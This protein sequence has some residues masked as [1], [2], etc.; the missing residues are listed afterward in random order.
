[1]ND[2]I[3]HNETF[4]EL[5]HDAVISAAE[6]AQEA[7]GPARV[8]IVAPAGAVRR[9][10]VEAMSR[11]GSAPDEAGSAR[12][13]RRLTARVRFDAVLIDAS[14]PRQ[15]A[16]RL[17][18][19]ITSSASAPAV[20]ML[21]AHPSLDS[22][23]RAIRSGACDLVGPESPEEMS[24]RVLAA[25]GRGRAARAR[26]ERVR[27]LERLCHKLNVARE[28]VVREVGDLCG[29]L[30]GAYQDLTG[31][32]GRI[33]M[34]SEFHGLVRQELEVEGLLRTTL[35]FLLA[36]VGSTNA[37]IFLPGTSGDFS[38]GAYI[39]YDCPK[40]AAEVMLDHLA[41]ELAPRYQR[42]TDLRR[43]DSDETLRRDLGESA[44]WME[45]RTLLVTG[46]H[47]PSAGRDRGGRAGDCI[48]VLA[49][50]RDRRTGFDA[51][52]ERSVR[53]ISDLFTEQLAR[54]I[55]IHHRHTPDSLGFDD[56]IDDLDLAA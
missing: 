33:A 15:S 46:C 34:A 38:L 29:G 39:N 20:V 51:D 44:H 53:V 42:V 12:E 36:K 43:V 18:E 52:A 41:D 32:V 8:L 40:D 47:E 17:C 24:R 54:V 14:L 49:V 4:P 9:M 2:R 37:G 50:F 3:D 5:E 27:R 25:A 45:G 48:A 28:E 22:A 55:R 31:E 6:Q 21:D 30:V 23:T 13:A 10:A 1:M 26:E 7:A 56:G 35:E 11:H 19:A 16:Y